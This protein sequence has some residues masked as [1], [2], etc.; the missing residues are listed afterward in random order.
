MPAETPQTNRSDKSKLV[1][2]RDLHMDRPARTLTC[3]NLAGSTADMHRIK[4]SDGRRR[5]LRVQEAA[6]LQSFPDWFEFSGSETSKFNQI[7]NAVPPMFAHYI[8]RQMKK[9]LDNL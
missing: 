5:R 7:G 9:Y 1:N 3:R 4:L 6:R 2:P 8:G